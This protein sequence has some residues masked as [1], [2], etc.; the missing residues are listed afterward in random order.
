VLSSRLATRPRPEHSR[1]WGAILAAAA[2]T[3]TVLAV[4][5]L[6]QSLTP[7]ADAAASLQ[8]T[9]S[10]PGQTLIGRETPVEVSFRNTG[11]DRAFNVAFSVTV[12][13]GVSV[14]SSDQ[15]PARTIVETNAAGDV[16][17]TVVVWENL[18][19]I[20]AG[21]VYR[22]N[23]SLHHDVGTGAP[24]LWEVGETVEAP[25]DAYF[26]DDDATVPQFQASGSTDPVTAVPP[27]GA[28]I[29]QAPSPTADST[30]LVPILLT[31][32]EPSPES[33]L[34]RGVH[35][36][37]TLYTLTAET[38]SQGSVGVTTID[39]W[40]PAGIEFL[41][42][43]TA[44]NS[45][46][47]EYPGSGP[48]NPGNAPGFGGATCY[49]PSSVETTSTVP[50]G[51]PAGVYTHVVWNIADILGGGATIPADTTV[52][53][54]YVAAIPQRANTLTF[55]G[56]APS[57][58]SGNQASNL[59]NNTG[60]FTTQGAV[61]DGNPEDGA[62]YTNYVRA[63]STFGGTTTVVEAEETVTAVDLSVYKTVDVPTI[64]QGGVSTWT[65]HLRTSEYVTDGGVSGLTVTDTTPDGLCPIGSAHPG[66]AGTTAPPPNPAYS[67]TSF[68]STNGQTTL[69][70]NVPGGPS[71]PNVT[72]DISFSTV[73]LANYVSGTGR[74]VSANDTWVN[75]ADLD[76]NVETFG[77]LGPDL[78]TGHVD[79]DVTDDTS[80]QQSGTSITFR[81]DVGVP[82][83]GADCGDGTDISWDP[84][85][86]AGVGPG[87]RVCFR[88]TAKGPDFLNTRD[89][90]L[91]DFLPV[92]FE[93]VAG[94]SGAG[95][96]NEVRPI[97]TLP[98]TITGGPA[99][100]QRLEWRLIPGTT[101]QPAQVA[102]VV[103][104]AD[105]TNGG[106]PDTI[107]DNGTS[108]DV[109]TNNARFSFQNTNGEVFVVPDSAGV[110]FA[111]AELGLEKGIT[112]VDRP[113]PAAD[114]THPAPGVPQ[115]TDV[116]AGTAVTYSVTVT[117]TGTRDA[118][119]AVVW[120]LLPRN[121]NSP[122]D[123]AL[124]ADCAGIAVPGGGTCD[125]GAGRIT[126][127]G[128]NVPA[129]DSVVLTYTWTLP[130]DT[131]LVP[132]GSEW[133]NHAGIVE[134]HSDTNNGPDF[135]YVPRDNI[136][137]ARDADANTDPA[138]D[139]AKIY[140][141]GITLT[142]TRTTA[143]DEPGNA[144]ADQA[145][146]GET[147]HYTVTALQSGGTATQGFVLSDDLAGTGQ[148]LDPASVVVEYGVAS[149]SGSACGSY[150]AAPPAD[151]D[152][153][154]PNAITVTRGGTVSPPVGTQAC[155]RLQFDATVDD[156]NANVRP[157]NVTNTADLTYDLDP[158][159]ATDTR[160][161]QSSVSTAIVEPDIAIT[162]EAD[163]TD[164]VLPGA[165]VPYT[166]V[167]SNVAGNAVSTAHGTVVTD[168][169]G[170][171][172]V[173]AVVDAGGGSVGPGPVITWNLGVDP[174]GDGTP[175][176]SP[177]TSV[178][179][180]YSV[181]LN[182]PLTAN[183]VLTNTATATTTSMAGSPGGERTSTSGCSPATCPGYIATDDAR[184]RV[185]SPTFAKV[186]DTSLTT[187]G[188]TATYT[189]TTTLFPGLDYGDTTITDDLGDNGTDATNASTYL[190]TVSAHC[191]NCDADDIAFFNQN[192][193]P[194]LNGTAT[195]TSPEWRF[196]NVGASEFV[197]V[198]T[199]TY[200]VR[201][202][203]LAGT[204]D[205]ST[206]TNTATLTWGTGSLDDT[207][208][209]D[210]AEPTLT[211]AKRV[212][213]NV[214]GGLRVTTSGTPARGEIGGTVSY[215]LVVENP[216]DWTAY[217][218]T[219]GDEPDSESSGGSC[220]G[221]S[222]L[223][224]PAGGV[225]GTTD[226]LVVDGTLGTGDA[227]LTWRIPTILPGQTVRIDY[228]L[229]VPATFPRADLD[230][231]GP[232]LHNHADVTQFYGLPTTEQTGGAAF[233]RTYPS[234]AIS[235][236]GYV[237]LD[238]GEI[239]DRVWLDLNGDGVQDAGEPGIPGVGVTVTW[240]GPDGVAG[241]T[242]NVTYQRTTGAN[243]SWSTNDVP[244]PPP[245]A[246][247][248]V[249]AGNYRVDIDTLTLPPGLAP[250]YDADGIGTPSTSA[251]TL[252]EDGV[253]LG[254]DFGYNGT[255]S[256]G[257]TVWFDMN[258]NGTQQGT[259]PGIANVIIDLVW[260]GP[261]GL[262]ATTGDNLD[263]GS[264]TT[265]ADGEYTFENLP[266]GRFRA[267]VRPSSVP[268]GLTATYDLTAPAN[269]QAERLLPEDEDADDVDFGYGGTGSVGDFVWFDI[270]GDGA[271][272]PAEPG[273]GGVDVDVTWWGFDGAFGGGDDI[274]VTTTTGPAGGYLIEGVPAGQVRV[275]VV[276][277]TL[278]GDV[279]PTFDLDGT[280]TPHT[281]LRTIAT[282]EDARN[283]D[284][285]YRG[286]QT[287]G[288][289]VWLDVDSDSFGPDTPGPDADPDEPP[290]PGVR[291]TVTWAGRDG[292]L[293]T[294]ADN[295]ILATNVETGADGRWAVQGVPSGV[296]RVALAG[297][298]FGSLRVSY[299]REGARDGVGI[300]TVTATDLDF[301]FGL[302][303]TASL[304]DDVWLDFNRNGTID[305][306]EP[307]IP[308]VR[309]S[310]RWGG[311]DDVLGNAD[312]ADLDPATTNPQGKYLVDNVPSGVSRVVVDPTSLP[313]GL[314]PVYDLDGGNDNRADRQIDPLENARDDDFGYA[315]TGRLGDFV[316]W[317]LDGDG[318]QD[319]TEP[320]LAGVTVT[321]DWAG[322]DDTFGNAD[323]GQLK[324]ATDA[325]GGY[326]FTGLPGGDYR[327]TI[328]QAD[329]PSGVR[330]TADPDGGADSVSALTLAGGASNL[331][332]DFGYVGDSE[333]GDLVWRDV[334][335]DG[336][337]QADEPALQGVGVSVRYLG[338][339]GVDGTDDDVTV[340]QVTGDPP[341]TQPRARGGVPVPGD[342][343]YL[344]TGLAPG[345]YVVTLDGDTVQAPDAPISDLDGGDPTV[346][347]LTLTDE[348]TLDADFAV[349]QNDVPEFD[350]DGAA[351]A[352]I[353]VECDGSVVVDP[354][355]FVTD[356][357]GDR[358]RIVK[359]SV[360]VPDDVVATL[361]DNGKLKIS[362]SGDKDFVV[363][364][365]VA[366]GRG[367]V[368]DVRVPVEVTS[369]CAE[370]SED[371]G[372][373]PGTGNDLPTWAP[374]LGL[375]LLLAG[376]ALTVVGVRRRRG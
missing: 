244:P 113:D 333:I 327:V 350:G 83:D 184:V 104:A 56:G 133:T 336:E 189:V 152:T 342:P 24:E 64:Q 345:K 278:P 339:D 72:Y 87:D 95:P 23:Y 328:T 42:C 353:Q 358:L 127:T 232:E 326:L 20:N 268:A 249:P 9:Q 323:D 54:V 307:R 137:P 74:P 146:I 27:S 263:L 375:S 220:L 308:G 194:E 247:H 253:D 168:D 231:A 47:E 348:P 303:G 270:N 331:D 3:A 151:V 119:D 160:T 49:E 29:E 240:F 289:L 44:D 227:C 149:P 94:S 334:N 86:A 77:P 140:S 37:Q 198:V 55:P 192:G 243:G 297:E 100:G 257:D 142:K 177:G 163:T 67:S 13:P 123:P 201:V 124:D 273:I 180:H 368:V 233:V 101:V 256:L 178:T 169:L 40:I 301:D 43:G 255:R 284:F 285:G 26:S 31:K 129:G 325:D 319:P 170:G 261:D 112:E 120:D 179:L 102:Q 332:Q 126:W 204:V 340:Q 132:A 173:D 71:G 35:D 93:Y 200:E 199:I 158:S 209:V 110:Q 145:T 193:T 22:F 39:D 17:D 330:V 337:R 225:V 296:I 370:G 245:P 236:D 217:D 374:W 281:A 6:P 238:G 309:L 230:P 293:A 372:G 315:G 175:G 109:F 283:V 265:D 242:D 262:L 346:T 322:F 25:V 279:V 251:L 7:R 176:L 97:E 92:G 305:A 298:R 276:A 88:L 282:G 70:W 222:R 341:T 34:L 46:R 234:A 275:T 316:W 221:D 324:Q 357:N 349:F 208:Q 1:T 347:R 310:T 172:E 369:D 14:S 207:A 226:Y 121:T 164:T 364:Y 103:F 155:V 59:D 159:A 269:G 91:V 362:T 219:V 4:V 52:S 80:Q 241:G 19:D 38:G 321:L 291:L 32:S 229:T 306:G 75:T 106:T 371:S 366:D 254:Q 250:T 203:N 154:T 287:I 185:A 107:P 148:T 89:T 213:T 114:E 79:N 190:R 211:L 82:A 264:Q 290:V 312:D 343:F 313:D 274:T 5:P 260:A 60:P 365:Q 111:E 130:T 355:A 65:L 311:F 11:D 167:V 320:G 294:Q 98:P 81:K 246:P 61:P 78:P 90:S 33:E 21:S 125:N 28:G 156:V 69:T 36:H 165:V 161:L 373:L 202:R 141:P 48:L 41:G 252:P 15:A 150:A 335:R 214:D 96:D 66:C 58:A 314:V 206:L 144:A 237:N 8:V 212:Q 352:G 186:A 139:T 361:T 304:G 63:G 280:G 188:D 136:N 228:T 376:A 239:G 224:V 115:V 259:E 99:T 122:G 68:N 295:V 134:Y 157:G 128:I 210:I 288:D 329:L 171:N 166:V 2:L 16:L 302:A 359:G 218:V 248:L 117:N 57:P 10:I 216:S 351:G 147:I 135:T 187:V 195:S 85:L 18:V 51:I 118:T 53:M 363:R 271:Q 360:D 73:A 356:A 318:V 174:D 367:G 143:V 138:D 30:L 191:T 183:D 162:K 258:R 235:A 299:D 50:S 286:A 267:T 108:G 197:R 272:G 76:A 205:G 116:V 292:L 338:P 62:T 12:P 131:G 266:A 181:R 153:S 105:L 277:S 317:D 84:D 196:G 300:A 354:F 182:A 215:Q 344:V 223:T 45:N